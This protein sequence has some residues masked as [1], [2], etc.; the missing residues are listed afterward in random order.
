[1]RANS[2]F[3]DYL[4]PFKK[5]NVNLTKEGWLVVHPILGYVSQI[6]KSFFLSLED[7]EWTQDTEEALYFK[8]PK[9]A[10]R[11]ARLWKGGT[12]ESKLTPQK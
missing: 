5:Y 3:I 1:M 12:I 2:V 4:F 7:F 10:G 11:L 6:K 9:Q 8:D